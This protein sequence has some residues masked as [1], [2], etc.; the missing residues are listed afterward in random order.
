MN[1]V[2]ELDNQGI[3]P[4]NAANSYMHMDSDTENRNLAS[5]SVEEY[6]GDL[7]AKANAPRPQSAPA[8]RRGILQDGESFTPRGEDSQKQSPHSRLNM[9]HV[10]KD[11]HIA[12]TVKLPSSPYDEEVAFEYL[13]EDDE[14]LDSAYLDS[15]RGS[16]SAAYGA[17]S[18]GATMDDEHWVEE[19]RRYLMAST[20]AHIPSA[21]ALR[22]SGLRPRPSSADPRL[23]HS[24]GGGGLRSSSAG[25]LAGL[26]TRQGRYS[27]PDS[28]NA[29]AQ[30]RSS[31][32]VR[33]RQRV[34]TARNS[35]E[36]LGAMKELVEDLVRN[37]A[38]KADLYHTIQ[39]SF[40]I[41]CRKIVSKC[42]F[43]SNILAYL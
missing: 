36:R 9:K 27:L 24:S 41:A 2:D 4:Y 37:T 17:T 18:G 35:T 20:D 25:R 33:A 29:Y 30:R 19:N 38:K 28:S 12:E 5:F 31:S 11:V 32:T 15:R 22:Q 34:S 6:I 43:F 13:P 26:A 7:Q 42:D 1:E 3:L 10:G 14:D 40:F 23:R 21:P 39:V 16:S 8:G